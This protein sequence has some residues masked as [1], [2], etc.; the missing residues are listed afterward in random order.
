M[1]AAKSAGQEYND[2][3]L[4][5]TMTGAIAGALTGA[6]VAAT[7]IMTLPVARVGGAAGLVALGGM[8]LRHQFKKK[9]YYD[10]RE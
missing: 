3:L 10:P 8:W 7:G 4:T 6:R 1:S 5:G 9:Q 2:G